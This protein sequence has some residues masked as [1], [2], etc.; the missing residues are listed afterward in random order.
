LAKNL[1]AK[2]ALERNLVLKKEEAMDLTLKVK[3]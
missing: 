2:M 3:V 1:V